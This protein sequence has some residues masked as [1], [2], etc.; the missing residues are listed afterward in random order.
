M[1]INTTQLQLYLQPQGL[2]RGC[3]DSAPHTTLPLAGNGDRFTAL[4]I[5][6][7]SN[8][9]LQ[10]EIVPLRELEDFLD[11][12]SAFYQEAFHSL[13]ENLTSKREACALGEKMMLYWDRPII[14]GV[15]NITPDSF[16][17]G[18]SFAQFE[19]AMDQADRMIK[20]GADIIDIGGESTKPGAEP[21]S[22][23][24]ELS[25]VLPAIKKLSDR[26]IPLSIDSRNAAV[27]E[28][29]IAMGAH[30]INDVSALTHDAAAI[31]VVKKT[32]APVIL[33]H[34]QGTPKTMQL[35]PSYDNAVLDIFDYLQARIKACLEAGIEKSK[36]II[37]P[38]IGFGKTLDHNF[39]ILANLS[40]LHGLGVPILIGASRKRFIG[41]LS[42][43]DI[44]SKRMPG[45]IAAGL[46]AIE[47]GA[48][49][50]RVHD[51]EESRQAVS[52][53]EAIKRQN[54]TF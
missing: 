27:M 49:I 20:S 18:G 54:A 47:Q 40:I 42:G 35:D 22:I 4:K 41:E 46:A 33:M 19:D 3:S 15:L 25:R 50:I 26:N 9:N 52:I 24:E 12:Q 6:T 30:I 44:A 39:E 28:Q 37:D 23:E 10:S 1:S 16:S 32:A 43:E 14:Q 34:A 5:I 38:G 29:A 48:H 7:R 36:I 2:L 17:D 45:S 8:G 31:E 53:F 11:N 21:V 13:L 51:V